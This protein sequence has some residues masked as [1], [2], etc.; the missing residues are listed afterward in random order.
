[1]KRKKTNTFLLA[2]LLLFVLAGPAARC[3]DKKDEIKNLV[4]FTLDTTRADRLSCYGYEKE[5]TPAIDKVARQ[6]VLFENCAS[7]SSIT[8]V[9]HASIFTGM[10]PYH[11]GLRSMHG[12][13]DLVMNHDTV[14]LAQ[15]LE[16]EGYNTA[17]FVSAFPVSRRY[18]LDRG[19]RMFDEEF[20]CKHPQKAVG[21]GGMV[22]TGTCQRRADATTKSALKWLFEHHRQ[23]F[24]VWV[25]YFDPHDPI[26][27]PPEEFRPET[28]PEEAGR[29][30]YLRDLYDGEIRF[31]DRELGKVVDWL[32]DQGLYENT[33]IVIVADHG[34]GLGD[35]DFWTHGILYQEQ[36]LLPLIFRVPGM[37]GKRVSGR[38]RSIDIMP[39]I[40]DLLGVRDPQQTDGKSLVPAMK[41]GRD[42]KDRP[43]Y[44]ESQNKFSMRVMGRVYQKDVMYSLTRGDYKYILNIT[45]AQEELYNLS[46]DPGEQKN[47]A[48]D[49]R[50][51]SRKAALQK[52][53][54]KRM[55]ISPV[56]PP[57]DTASPEVIKKLKSLGYTAQ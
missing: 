34:E 15:A 1:M 9:S 28:G 38:V 31:M 19:F 24:F 55:K 7:C 53:L 4:V 37:E 30:E 25:H 47:L 40:L 10:Y 5:T 22:D 43:A 42:I 11:H 32:R 54:E 35:H 45:G 41:S 8:P 39:T 17:A 21:K 48:G 56:P 57:L 46:R 33:L 50:Y 26:L 51:S 18:G 6:G 23:N 14:T 44:A 52:E 2:V 36:V 13:E 29:K 16:K 20:Q 49:E 12:T 3:D 27:L